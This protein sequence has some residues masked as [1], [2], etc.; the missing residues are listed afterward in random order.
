VTE[1]RARAI[2]PVAPALATERVEAE[3]TA[4]EIDKFQIPAAARRT[5]ALLVGHLPARVAAQHDP[6]V[7]AVRLAWEGLVV[8]APG[9]AG[10]VDGGS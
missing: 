3:G 5:G 10:A 1:E 7:R 9:A 8:E 2:A 6:V 4:L